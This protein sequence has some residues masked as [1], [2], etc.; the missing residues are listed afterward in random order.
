[1]DILI[2]EHPYADQKDLKLIG[3]HWLL[4]YIDDI[5]VLGA[6]MRTVKENTQTSIVI[7]NEIGL[8][9][10]VYGH[11]LRPACSAKSQHTYIG[12]KSFERVELL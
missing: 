1:V 5:S 6:N 3:T 9:L 10:L 2:C 12:N 7:S 11:I 8:E 4:F